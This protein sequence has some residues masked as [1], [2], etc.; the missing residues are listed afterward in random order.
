MKNKRKKHNEKSLLPKIKKDIKDFCLK[1]EGSIDKETVV[2]MGLALAL[3]ATAFEQKAFADH[4]ATMIHQNL[5]FEGA[6]YGSAADGPGGHHS[7]NTGHAS[8]G[9]HGSHGQW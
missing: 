9:S 2:K 4:T 6:A 7:G 8:H 5:F 3:M 1:E